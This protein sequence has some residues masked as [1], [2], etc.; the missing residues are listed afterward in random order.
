MAAN[1]V[2][3]ARLAGA[4]R[5]D[6][7]V[8]LAFTDGQAEIVGYYQFAKRTGEMIDGEKGHGADPCLRSF[9]AMPQMPPGMNMTLKTKAAPMIESQ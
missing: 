5:T 4:V 1:L 7:D 2:D 6:D 3:Q 9:C 8:T